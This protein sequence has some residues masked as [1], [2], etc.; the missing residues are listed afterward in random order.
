LVNISTHD[1]PKS[2]WLDRTV[3]KTA[4]DNRKRINV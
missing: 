4:N 3:N 2:A 1:K